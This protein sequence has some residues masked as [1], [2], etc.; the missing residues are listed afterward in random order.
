MM[1]IRLAI[2]IFTL[3]LLGLAFSLSSAQSQQDNGVA[4]S[5]MIIRR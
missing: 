3:T 5:T 2:S 4:G 1:L